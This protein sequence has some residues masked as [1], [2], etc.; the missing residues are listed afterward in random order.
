MIGIEIVDADGQPAGDLREHILE[1]AFRR[2][3][4]LLGCGRSTIR[5]APPLII[6]PEDAEIAVSILD[7]A[8]GA[9]A[10]QP[11]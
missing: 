11:T 10:G 1:E 6:D 7:D 4:L 2:G 5:L 8:I 9:V 3:L